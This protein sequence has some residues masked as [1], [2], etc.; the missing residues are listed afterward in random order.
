MAKRIKKTGQQCRFCGQTGVTAAFTE[1]TR[2]TSGEFRYEKHDRPGSDVTPGDMRRRPCSMADTP[3]GYVGWPQ[4][5]ANA[6]E[7][8]LNE[9]AKRRR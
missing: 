5:A 2:R 9:L 4:W 8:A 6:N 1:P 3:V 7:R